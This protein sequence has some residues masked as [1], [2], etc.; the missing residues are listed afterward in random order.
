MIKAVLLEYHHSCWSLLLL[1]DLLFFLGHIL[2]TRAGKQPE[3]YFSYLE[4]YLD[5][6][7]QANKQK[8]NLERAGVCVVV[9]WGFLPS[10]TRYDHTIN[11]ELQFCEK[12]S[13]EGE[14]NIIQSA[15]FWWNQNAY[16]PH[17]W[18]QSILG[19]N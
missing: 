19:S 11:R 12:V 9:G 18:L 14:L 8:N 3:I 2:S 15:T 5:A 4:C 6:I 16:D 17:K 13:H 10:V 7:Q 1:S